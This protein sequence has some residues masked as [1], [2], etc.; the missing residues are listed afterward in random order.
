VRAPGDSAFDANYKQPARTSRCD[1]C[2]LNKVVKGPIYP[3]CSDCLT[4]R[5]F[6]YGKYGWYQP[7]RGGSK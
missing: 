5:G 6:V 4:Q 1:T 2:H 3:T 7:N